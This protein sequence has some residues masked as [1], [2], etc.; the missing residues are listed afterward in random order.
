MM[1]ALKLSLPSY[2]RL[3]FLAL[4]IVG[5]ISSS[6]SFSLLSLFLEYR[7]THTRKL[8]CLS[9]GHTSCQGKN[10]YQE[11]CANLRPRL[12]MTLGC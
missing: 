6:V 4:N 1:I 8:V 2:K 12:L 9:I 5:L 11:L 7:E 10:Y 3:A